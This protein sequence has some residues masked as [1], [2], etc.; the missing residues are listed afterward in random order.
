[1]DADIE[2][3]RQ[4]VEDLKNLT[5]DTNRIVHKM[6]RGVWWVRLWT[7][8]FWLAVLSVSG[9][10]YYYWAQPYVQKVEQAYAGFQQN[11]SQAQNFFQQTQQLFSSFFTGGTTTRP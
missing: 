7:I 9:A 10:A 2:E 4:K 1:M 6:R 5:Q 8:V 11:A 3:L